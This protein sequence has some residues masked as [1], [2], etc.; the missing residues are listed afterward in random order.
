MSDNRKQV[1]MY[2]DGGCDPNPGGPGGYGTVLLSQGKRKEL[3]GGFRASTNNRM[4]LY[5]VL[6][7]LEALKEPCAVT[8]YSDS[9]YVVN[10]IN[11]GWARKWKARNWWRSK[12]ERAANVDLWERLLALCDTHTVTFAWVRGHVGVP[13]NERCDQLAM[14]A[15]RQTGLPVDEGYEGEKG[16]GYNQSTADLAPAAPA[17][18]AVAPPQHAGGG[19]VTKITQE[20][21]PCR[22]CN[23]PVVKKIPARKRNKQQAYFYEYY[24]YCPSCQTNYMVDEAKRYT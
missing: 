14:Q 20:G 23:T 19:K 10:A 6:K 1:V 21:Q 24:L 13:E 22:K 3:S 7:G 4:E 16:N 8:V 2:T 9:R 15:L 5:A 12:T 17:A 18:P 11:K